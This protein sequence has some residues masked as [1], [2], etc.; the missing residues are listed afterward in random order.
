MSDNTK[1]ITETKFFDYGEDLLP[2][3]TFRGETLTE[4]RLA[5]ELYGELNNAKDNAILVFH[6]LTGSQH[7]RGFTE[8][9]DGVSCWSEECQTGWYSGSV[10]PGLAID[11]DKF[12]V[13]V[14]NYL[15]GCYGTT[16]PGSIDPATGAP[17][18]S[19]FPEITLSDIVDSQMPLIDALGIDRLHAVIGA[20]VGGMMCLSLATRY[21]ERVNT[22]I[23]IAAGLHTTSLQFI[24]N[25]EQ[26]TAILSDPN[27]NGGD[28]YDREPPNAGLALAR[29]IGHKTFVSLEA[30]SDRARDDATARTIGPAGY[31]IRHPLE[32]Y[33]WYQGQKFLKRFDANT[34]VRLMGAWQHFDLLEEAGESDLETLLS[35]CRDQTYMIFS[36]DSDVC[37]YPSEQ[38]E[39]V[40]ELTAA[41]VTAR[42]VT[43]H[44]EKGHDSFLVEPELFAP[45]LIDTLERAKR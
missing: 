18:G 5:Y 38:E 30:M 24:H 19:T 23:P 40:R 45:H 28:Y 13:I 41:G 33:M 43:V 12:A 10:G 44:S 42:R 26:T 14:V 15:G 17:Y 22:V 4:L 9:V 11:T 8:S 37:F 2:F 6:A 20:S 36:I 35:R 27:F 34:Y 32:S 29:M 1:V 31:E 25:F 39:M 3:K 21:P 7:A 16:G